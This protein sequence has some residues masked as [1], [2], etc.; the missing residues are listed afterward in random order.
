[1]S[2]IRITAATIGVVG[3]TWPFARLSASR[4]ELRLR[5][6]FDSYEF[7]PSQVVSLK[8]YGFLPRFKRGLRVVHARPDYPSKIVFW[9]DSDPDELIGKIREAGFVPVAPP[10]SE[11]QRRGMP[12]RWIW[13]VFFIVI[14]NC[15]F[16]VSPANKN[17]PEL[18]VLVPLL[19]AFLTAWGI[20]TSP[21]LQQMVLKDGRSINEDKGVL[22]LL[23]IVSALLFVVFAIL[24]IAVNLR[25]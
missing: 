5:W 23:Q 13:V 24:K 25:N 14:W 9:C 21:K 16:L 22:S 18:F 4:D 15:L 7:E 1:M 2:E 19:F 10:N 8:P 3:G 17:Q 12:A 6:L 11:V 20:K